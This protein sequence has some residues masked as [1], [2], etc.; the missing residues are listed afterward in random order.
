MPCVAAPRLLRGRFGRTA[1]LWRRGSCSSSS[2][3]R[4]RPL[5]LVGGGFAQ[6]FLAEEAG[7]VVGFLEVAVDRGVA[8]GGHVIE[9]LQVLHDQL[10]DRGGRQ[11]GL[12]HALELAG[13]GGGA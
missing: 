7:E 4:G 5:A 12:A 9:L 3:D 6:A 11:F 8:D 1:R 2:G 10:A 13:G